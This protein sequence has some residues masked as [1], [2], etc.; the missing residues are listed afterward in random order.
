MNT[1]LV[2]DSHALIHRAYHAIP[3]LTTKGGQPTNALYGFLGLLHK[4]VKDIQP[5]HIAACFD[6]P[7]ESFRAKLL[8]TYQATR[9]P[10]DEA[11]KSQFSLV[12]EAVKAAHIALFEAPNYEADDAIG[13]VVTQLKSE[14]LLSGEPFRIIIF[15]GDKD[16]FQLVDEHV[17]VLTPQIGFSK[18]QLYG[19]AEVV[20]KMFVAPEYVADLKALSGDP[21]DNYKGLHKIGPKTAAKLIAEFGHVENMDARFDA[22]TMTLLRTMK[23]VS[24]IVTDVPSID[25]HLQDVLFTGYNDELADVIRTYEVFSLLPRFFAKKQDTDNKPEPKPKVIDQPQSESLF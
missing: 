6:T 9:K 22:E 11:L 1:I 12:R 10:T 4:A 25:A 18:A 15:S 7:T 8:S 17:F 16:M 13:T 21:S 5:T 23:Q 3:P 20:T 14:A 19:P 24:T 2:V